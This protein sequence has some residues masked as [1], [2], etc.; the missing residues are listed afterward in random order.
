MFSEMH[1]KGAKDPRQV[2]HMVVIPRFKSVFYESKSFSH[3]DGKYCT[4]VNHK[5]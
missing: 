3:P 4:T 5:E 1:S 2:P